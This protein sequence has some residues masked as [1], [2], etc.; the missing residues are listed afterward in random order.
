MITDAIH[1]TSDG[2]L[3]P[4]EVD[5]AIAESRSG[6]GNYWINV[7][8]FSPDQLLQWLDKLRLSSIVKDRLSDLGKFTQVV[9]L[10]NALV[11]EMR[12]LSEENSAETRHVA[13]LCQKNLIVSFIEKSIASADSI[14]RRI[15]ELEFFENST[16]G[17]LISLLIIQAEHVARDVRSLRLRVLRLDET[18]DNDPKSVNLNQI[19]DE[20]NEL[21]R[22]LSVA[23]EQFEC[24][25]ALAKSIRHSVDFSTL[26][27]TVDLL[28]S[29]GGS[30]E[31]MAERL[32][33]RVM[34]LRHRYD[35]IQ[36]EKV[37]H[38]LAILTIVS[39]VFMPLTL[40]AGI[41]GMNFDNMPE[42]HKPF[43]YPMALGL[44][45]VIATVMVLFFRKRGWFD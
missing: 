19:L 33:K 25:E 42:L 43:G 18:M 7:A 35:A 40:V 26:T 8:E 23:E 5:D 3:Q 38:R 27:A 24:F 22:L 4:C 20:K 32:E 13:I 11:L 12:V 21:L 1:I 41:W 10:P 36:Q 9:P 44:M 28:L 31:R 15:Q 34:D 30:T 6:K 16:N 29:I 37:N 45:I 39:A 14:D 17:V 2:K